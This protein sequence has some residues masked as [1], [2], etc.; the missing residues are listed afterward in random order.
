ME[1]REVHTTPNPGG[2]G[3]VNEI[4]GRIVSRHRSRFVAEMEGRR[5]A[6]E[7]SAEHVIHGENGDV[8]QRILYSIDPKSTR[9]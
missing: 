1:R 2:S 8:R 4:D 6:T 9:E 3:W 7:R 5:L